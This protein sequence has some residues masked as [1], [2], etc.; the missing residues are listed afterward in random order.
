MNGAL[1]GSWYTY[2]WQHY[3][4]YTQFG[5]LRIL[6]IGWEQS[7][8]KHPKL[9]P[10]RYLLFI[11]TDI[12]S[13]HLLQASSRHCRYCWQTDIGFLLWGI[14]QLDFRL[15]NIKIFVFLQNKFVWL[16]Y[17]Y[18]KQ[19]KFPRSIKACKIFKFFSWIKQDK[20]HFLLKSI[21]V[22][23]MWPICCQIGLAL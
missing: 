2:I 22:W 9:P 19:I 8:D 7:R 21:C 3:R 12:F 18:K 17:E 4:S 15:S 23:N 5:L 6:P 1:L 11:Y 13:R 14:R 16:F 20:S 10:P